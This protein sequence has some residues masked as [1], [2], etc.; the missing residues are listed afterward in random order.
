MARHIQEDLD[1]FVKGGPK[2][3]FSW[4]TL[5][6]SQ[7]YRFVLGFVLWVQQCRIYFMPCIMSQVAYDF[8]PQKAHQCGNTLFIDFSQSIYIYLGSLKDMGETYLLQEIIAM[9]HALIGECFSQWPHGTLRMKSIF[10]LFEWLCGTL[11]TYSTFPLLK[12]PQVLSYCRGFMPWAPT[13]P[14]QRF[15]GFASQNFETPYAINRGVS[16]LINSL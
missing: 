3:V 15:Q 13:Y 16:P 10:H 12:W 2:L 6:N 11:G 7:Q 8:R 9:C 4:A 14:S 1:S 5:D